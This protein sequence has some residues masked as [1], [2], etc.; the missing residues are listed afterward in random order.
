[1]PGEGNFFYKNFFRISFLK[2]SGNQRELPLQ[3]LHGAGFFIR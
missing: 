1:M 2:N 3:Y